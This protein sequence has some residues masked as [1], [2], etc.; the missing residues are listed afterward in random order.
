MSIVN[1]LEQELSGNVDLNNTTLLI[2]AATIY[3]HEENYEAALRVLNQSETL[4]W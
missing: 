3:C 4:E 1:D 2:V